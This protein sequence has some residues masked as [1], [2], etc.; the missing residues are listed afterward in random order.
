MLLLE[1]LEQLTLGQNNMATI[2][3]HAFLG[4][5]KLQQLEIHSAEHLVS[6]DSHALSANGDL[7]T[8]HLTN[9][10][11]V[12]TLP[13]HVFAHSANLRRLSLRDNGLQSLPS[14]LVPWTQLDVMDLSGNPFN[15]QCNLLWLRNYLRQKSTAAVRS[16]L[17]SPQLG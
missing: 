4:L 9:C 3:A 2:A 12:S 8:L 14:Q 15:C 11:K 10:K 17:L 16:A 5:S 7:R 6:I 13:D 1:R